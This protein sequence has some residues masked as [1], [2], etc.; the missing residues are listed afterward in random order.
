MRVIFVSLFFGAVYESVISFGYLFCEFSYCEIHN[1]TD[2]FAAIIHNYHLSPH[3]VPFRKSYLESCI[4]RFNAMIL[5]V[6]PYTFRNEFQYVHFDFHQDPYQEY[7]Y[8]MHK[9]CV[10]GLFT[11]FAGTLHLYQEWTYPHWAYDIVIPTHRKFYS[12]RHF[13]QKAAQSYS[14]QKKL[15]KLN[16]SYQA[17]Y[18]LFLIPGLRSWDT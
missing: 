6:H 5:Q 18:P 15:M 7:E 13:C 9:I 11:D 4:L 12:T 10:D 3:F 8:W 1:G 2:K 16:C 14:R 17:R